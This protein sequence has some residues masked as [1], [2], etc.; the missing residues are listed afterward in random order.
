[1]FKEIIGR[2][3]SP[4]KTILDKLLLPIGGPFVLHWNFQTSK[5]KINL[6]AYYKECFDAWSEVNGKTPSCYE[7][8]INEIIW[9]NKFLCYDKKSMYRRDIVNLGFVKIRDLISANNT[10]SCDVSSLTNP[11][12]RFFFMSII[13]SI[14]RKALTY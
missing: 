10:F 2:L 8:I 6:P 5:L 13:N 1:M 4:W 11:E 12:Q 9:N 14:C 7:E 3:L